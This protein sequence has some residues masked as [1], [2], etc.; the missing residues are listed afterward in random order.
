MAAPNSPPFSDSFACC[1]HSD[2]LES[3]IVSDVGLVMRLEL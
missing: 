1:M 2:A 3:S